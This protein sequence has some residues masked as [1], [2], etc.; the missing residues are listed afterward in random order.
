MPELSCAAT[1]VGNPSDALHGKSQE[2]LLVTSLKEYT[3]QKDLLRGHRLHAEI[4]RSGLLETNVF[5]GSSLV[6]LYAKCGKIEKAEHVFNEVSVRDAVTWNALLAGY[7]HH[8]FCE[9]ALDSFE[10][11]QLEGFLPTPVSFACA[12]KVC[13]SMDVLDKG[14]DLHTQI[15]IEGLLEEHLVVANALVD[16]YA[17]CGALLEAQEV[18]DD[19]QN[20]DVVSWNALIAG[21]TQHE[22]GE[23]ALNC[24]EQM[25]I[26]RFPPDAVTFPSIFKA[27][28]SL[29]ALGKGKDV[30]A[31]IVEERLVEIDTH[32]GS[33]L[34]DM[35]AKCGMLDE[36][37]EVFDKLPVKDGVLWNALISG[38]AHHEQG[39][40]AL[41][42]FTQMQ[43]NGFS[44][45]VVTFACVLKACGSFKALQNGLEIHAQ[46]VW[47]SSLESDI[48]VSTALV[49]MYAK[50]GALEEAQEVFEELQ[51][52]TAVSWNALIGGFTQFGLSERALSYF[53]R[54]QQEG[55][56]PDTISFACALKAC[57]SLGDAY[58]GQELHR[59]I[60]QCGLSESLVVG[61]ALV[62]MYANCGMLAEALEMFDK[63]P[64]RDVVAWSAL[65]VAFTQLG[66]DEL[67]F[68]SF[69]QMRKANILP[70]CVTF[71]ILLTTC[72]H[73][74]LLDKGEMYFEMIH[75]GYGIIPTLQ[76]Y[77][78][79]ID[80]YGRVNDLHKAVL[81]IEKMPVLANASVW[82]TL[83]SACRCSGNMKLALWAFNY[84]V[85][86]NDEIDAAYVCLGDIYAGPSDD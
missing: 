49:D 20:R 78:C 36:V 22:R 60:V 50:C 84:A 53:H 47:Q 41:N 6:S 42:S 25:Q 37:Q 39:E 75:Q 56:S 57:G 4:V 3:K 14:R 64:V 59:H 82:H 29:G 31:Q 65:M 5:V 38:Y 45:N 61:N 79:L 33:A 58:V 7:A 54:M 74:G 81:V 67:V 77:A 18:F 55:F 2:V 34:V 11:L 13:G 8:G 24:F 12:L 15:V 51:F 30:H 16:M 35:Y 69:N 19:I 66:K 68:G 52:R 26:A 40:K 83:L 71:A 21:Y 44:P 76:H 28:G 72:S 86:S 23:E 62:D 27:C 70:D 85:Q 43:L 73:K 10:R 1:T 48:L 9:E 32:I 46:I 80:A 63:L 17:K